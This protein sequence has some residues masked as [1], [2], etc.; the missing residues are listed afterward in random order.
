MTPLTANSSDNAAPEACANDPMFQIIYNDSCIYIE[1]NMYS[2]SYE[3]GTESIFTLL[4]ISEL[5]VLL[6]FDLMGF[7]ETYGV[8]SRYYLEP[9]I[10]FTS[11]RTV[12]FAC[13]VHR[14]TDL[15]KEDTALTSFV[16]DNPA[17]SAALP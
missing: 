9:L 1:F 5:V 12:F 14:C 4:A 8:L 16:N 2:E 7:A 11:S 10:S 13:S 17:R 15:S 3:T 6:H